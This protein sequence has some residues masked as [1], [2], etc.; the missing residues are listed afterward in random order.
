MI[1]GFFLGIFYTVLAFLVGLLPV[2]AFPPQI[3]S[4]WAYMWGLI[5]AVTFLFPVD[6]LLLILA[7]WFLL[8]KTKLIVLI[9]KVIARMSRGHLG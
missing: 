1:I 3:I 8:M 2:S 7:L 4:G 9:A 6:Q 5:N